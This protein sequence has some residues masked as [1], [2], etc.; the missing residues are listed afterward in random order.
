MGEVRKRLKMEGYNICP[1]SKKTLISPVNREKIGMFYR[2]KLHCRRRHLW[3]KTNF[4]DE[5]IIEIGNNSKV[6]V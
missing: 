5:T 4:N 6:Y 1:C 3:K 2:L